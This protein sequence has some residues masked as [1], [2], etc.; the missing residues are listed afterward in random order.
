MFRLGRKF[1]SVRR[2]PNQI[3]HHALNLGMKEVQLQSDRLEAAANQKGEI[4]P[5][6]ISSLEASDR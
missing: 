4:V 5:S 1:R 3:C 2:T 6:V